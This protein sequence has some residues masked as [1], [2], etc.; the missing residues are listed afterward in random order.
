MKLIAV[1]ND[2]M[3]ID[4]L[5]QTLLAIEPYIDAVILREKSK[6]DTE[7]LKLIQK[8][9]EVNFNVKKMIVHGKPTIANTEQIDKVQL[10][11]GLPLPDL[12]RQYPA[13]LFGK[14]VHSL[15]EAIVA[16]ADGAE[17]VLYG[18]LFKTNSKPGL[19]PRGTDDLR[20]IVSSLTIPVYAIGGI[21]PSH[22]ERL[23]EVGIAGVAIMS[24]IFESE[25]PK[26][27][28]KEYYDAIHT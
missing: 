7:I 25:H 1:T 11:G 19:Q 17:S 16:E 5:I 14:S 8:L 18:H 28:A 10:P 27:I 21:R 26:N 3:S 4:E 2:R 15:E 6:T 12:M 20:R 13:L 9:K 22:I 24:T 23:R